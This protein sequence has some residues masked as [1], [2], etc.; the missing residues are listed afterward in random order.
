MG[1][2]R[3]TCHRYV[4]EGRPPDRHRSPHNRQRASLQTGHYPPMASASGGCSADEFG[5]LRFQN[6]RIVMERS[7]QSMIRRIN[8]CDTRWSATR[9][10]PSASWTLNPSRRPQ[11]GES[12]ATIKKRLTD[13]N[14]NVGLMPIASYYKYWH[15]SCAYRMWKA[16]NGFWRSIINLFFGMHEIRVEEGRNEG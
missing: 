16:S 2:H 9:C 14:G 12:A 4:A 7:S 11:Q 15:L 10:R 13:A 5:S 8:W 1:R 3:A 6:I